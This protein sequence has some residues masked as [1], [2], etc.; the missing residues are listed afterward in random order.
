MIEQTDFSKGKPRGQRVPIE[1]SIPVKKKASRATESKR[2]QI[3]EICVW[4]NENYRVGVF[5]TIVEFRRLRKSCEMIEME[6]KTQCGGFG[7]IRH[8]ST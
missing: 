1:P 2:I 8:R 5:V 6:E 3:F 4:D 7:S